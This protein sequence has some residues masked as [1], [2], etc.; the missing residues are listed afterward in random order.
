MVPGSTL[1]EGSSF[2]IDTRKPLSL[3]SFPIAAAVTPFPTELTTPPVTK[4]NWVMAPPSRS[5]SQH[6]ID[7]IERTARSAFDGPRRRTGAQRSCRPRPVDG[8]SQDRFVAPETGFE[9]LG[10]M[11]RV[12]RLRAGG[13]SSLRS[14]P[15]VRCPDTISA[16]LDRPSADKG[17]QIGARTPHLE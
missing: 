8:R 15:T 3:S 1:I 10:R 11:M 13:G 14:L 9:T 2:W 6:G 5:Q 7:T 16:A 17:P 12:L 4:I